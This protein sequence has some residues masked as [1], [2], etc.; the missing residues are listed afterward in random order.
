[1]AADRFHLA[2]GREDPTN[3]ISG[4]IR[5]YMVCGY[6]VGAK[7]NRKDIF[8]L[9]AKKTN[10]LKRLGKGERT[11]VKKTRATPTLNLTGRVS[12]ASENLRRSLHPEEVR[13]QQV[14]ERRK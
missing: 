1:V 13:N 4:K 11:R 10:S 3:R 14:E 12:Q 9:A 7:K 8:R 5:N 2:G 6:P